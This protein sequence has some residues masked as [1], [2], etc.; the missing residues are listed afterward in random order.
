[1]VFS[2][3]EPA[4]PWDL[5]NDGSVSVPDLVMLLTDFGPCPLFSCQWSS[6]L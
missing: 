6:S 5:D 4:C 1:V 3:S 2:P